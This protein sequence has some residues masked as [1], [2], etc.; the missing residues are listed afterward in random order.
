MT[1]KRI[2]IVGGGLGGL[3]AAI[4]L[5]SQGH[6]VTVLEKNERIGGK[7]NIR[8]GEGYQFDT[9]PSI[10][11]MPWVLEA[12]FNRAGR[13]VH[14]YMEI[15]RVEPQWRT[16][17]ED[18]VSIDLKGD[19]PDM[20]D[21][22]K[23]V[24]PDDAA[25]FMNYL[26]YS[27]QMYEL[28]MKSF[29]N[30]SISG[31]SELRKLHSLRELMAFDPMKTLNEGTERYIKDPHIKQFI[32]FL[33]MYVG[34]SPYQAPAVLSQL[35]YVQFGLGNFYVKG[36]MYNIV[37]GMEQLLTE[38]NVTIR[39]ETPV[40]GIIQVD[41]VAKGVRLE[42][43]EEVHADIVVSNL[44]AI[45]TYRQLLKEHP[46]HKTQAKKL[47]KFEPSV[48]GLVLLLGLR[49]EYPQLAHHNFFFSKD[50][51]E[52]FKQIFEEK[53]P[54]DDPT[55]YIGISSKSDPSQAPEGKENHFV[56]THVPPLKEGETW[57][58]YKTSYRETVISKLERNGLTTIRDD[59]EF[60]MTFTPD[61]LQSLYGA[62]GG[63]IYGV[64]ADKKKNGGFKIPSKS[65]L[66]SQLYFVGGSTHPGGGVPM[67]TLS[68]Q[69]TADLIAEELT[70]QQKT[71]VR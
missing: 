55:V 22:I 42:C 67:V 10:L 62:N 49:R 43:G 5:A 34:S 47:E 27:A 58:K 14:D 28:C 23:K 17:F 68:G 63:S 18:G 16:F 65:E 56:L 57:E 3:S 9:G 45:P 37:R 46:Q 35:A 13:D 51:E 30:K 24:A 39:T 61:D 7:C 50:P 70:I 54:A 15:E 6:D 20:L 31:L 53:R 71:A 12:L 21:E 32:N 66:I 41:S 4:S 36:G 59:I 64:V 29:Y 11:T 25:P 60:E 33:V 40:K 44:E 48:S 1:K 69:L 8:S 38:L 26:N 19:L 52:E 2:V